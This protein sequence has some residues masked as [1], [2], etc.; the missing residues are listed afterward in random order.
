MKIRPPLLSDF[1]YY[2]GWHMLIKV[3]TKS[4]MKNCASIWPT[5]HFNQT[6]HRFHTFI[7][8][9]HRSGSICWPAMTFSI[10]LKLAHDVIVVTYISLQKRSFWPWLRTPSPPPVFKR[11]FDTKMYCKIIHSLFPQKTPNEGDASR[12]NF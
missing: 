8:S 9:T 2:H 10:F 12:N 7:L 5:D 4:Q 3:T 1:F 11:R 6:I